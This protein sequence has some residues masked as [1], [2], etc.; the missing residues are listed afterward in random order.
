MSTGPAPVGGTPH[1][2]MGSF[3]DLG[4]RVDAPPASSWGLV[5]PDGERGMAAFAAAAEVTEAARLVRRGECFGLDYPLDAF[6]PPISPA[7]ASPRQV[8]VSRHPD[9]RDDYVE[10]LWLQASSHVDGLRHRRHG[11]YGFYGGVPDEAISAGTPALGVNRWAEQPIVGRGVLLDVSASRRGRGRPIDHANGEALP[12][13]DLVEALSDQAVRDRAC[14]LRPGDLLLLHTGWA[15]WYLSD[16]EGPERRR[17]CVEQRCT[18]LV[19][20]REVIAWVWDNRLALV[21]SDTFALEVLPPVPGSPYGSPHDRGMMH[22][23]LIALPGLP[24]GEL[25]RL[26]DLAADCELSGSY[27]SLVVVKP[28]NLTGGVG[29]PANAVAIR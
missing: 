18:G 22:Q 4:K 5:G 27:E 13:E 26:Q 10:R 29:S 16:P 3:S 17:A 2:G 14:V 12:L 11:T 15:S 28:L 20:G 9:H 25:W 24:I 21:A 6:D 19:Q 8:I 7:R 1:P 23:E